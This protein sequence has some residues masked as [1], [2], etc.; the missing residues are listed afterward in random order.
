MQTEPRTARSIG[1]ISLE[2]SRRS[3][4]IVDVP[5]SATDFA[6]ELLILF[7]YTATDPCSMAKAKF[8]LKFY[9]QFKLKFWAVEVIIYDHTS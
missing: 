6:Q 5:V 9:A 8:K 4:L 2:E 3:N 7:N 1:P